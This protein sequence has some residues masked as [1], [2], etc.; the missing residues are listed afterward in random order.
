MIRTVR[1]WLVAA[2]AAGL[3][4]LAA[5][6]PGPA[7]DPPPAG[8]A[9]PHAEAQREGVG[10]DYLADSPAASPGAPAPYILPHSGWP[11]VQFQDPDPLLDRPYSAQPGFYANVEADVLWPHLRNQLAGPVQN[12]ITGMS[13]QVAFPG[14]KLDPTVSP[15]VELGYRLADNWGSLQFGYRGLASRGRDLVVTGPD[16]AFQG[17]ADQVGRVD[18]NMADFA[19]VSREYSLDPYWNMR[20]GIGA[21]MMFTFFDSR[22]RFLA[23]GT[24]AG[25]VLAQ[26]ESDHLRSY[27]PWGFLDVE[28]CTGIPGLS[29][30]GRLEAA[31]LF[32]R[33]KQLYT[34]T[35]AGNPG[36]LPT[37]SQS[38]FDGS[39]GVV[40]LREM[41]G[42]SYT[43]PRWNY[44]RFLIGY[45]YETFFQLGRLSPTS[46]VI[47]TRGQL[48]LQ[49]L[50]LRAEFNF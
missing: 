36:E 40:Q 34:E 19:Y 44:S 13:D 18:F 42:L 11:K 6:A 7:A 22:V 38:R 45:Q 28:R 30:F 46:G 37:T 15:H 31:D 27:G 21:R 48:D 33:A 20:W 29:V 24:D 9:Q 12:P 50:V 43:V 23:P 5:P 3:T 41:V 25:S 32:S 39:V 26:S 10:E 49:G 2:A 16:D 47:D 35:V 4:A 1:R 17:A 14:N 8:G